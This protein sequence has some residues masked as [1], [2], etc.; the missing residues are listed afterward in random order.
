LEKGALFVAEKGIT[1]AEDSDWIYYQKFQAGDVS[2]FNEL[3]NKYKTVLINLA[4][5]YVREKEAAEDIAQEVLIKVYEKRV[6]QEP[7]AKFSTW[8]YRVTVNASL[9]VIRKKKYFL[10]SLDEEMEGEEGERKT[11]L[12]KMADPQGASPLK[13]LAEEELR[14]LVQKEIDRLPEKFRSVIL[15]YQFEEMSYREIA[16]ILDISEKAVERRLYHAKE[17][18]R[19]KL[20][21]LLG[22]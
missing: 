16:K 15:L 7:H 1:P 21:R 20:S 12:E 22:Y 13:G 8:L 19:R 18:L 9:D 10:R 17:M 6:T 3:F 4:F 11:L 2:A 14:V 5:R